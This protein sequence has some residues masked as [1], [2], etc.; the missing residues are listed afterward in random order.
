MT[1][2]QATTGSWHTSEWYASRVRRTTVILT[3]LGITLAFAYAAAIALKRGDPLLLAPLAVALVGLAVLARPTAGVYLLFGIALLFEQTDVPGV[4]PLTDQSH[5]FQRMDMYSSIPIP[6]SVA[7]LLMVLTLASLGVRWIAGRHA[8]LRLGPFGWAVAAYGS[9]FVF[10]ALIGIARGSAWSASAAIV[11]L[12]GPL[13]LCLMYVLATNLIL[14]R[15]QFAILTWVF[16]ILVGLKAI[17]AIWAYQEGLSLPY[18]LDAATGH[19]DVVFFNL[20]LAMLV[21]GVLLGLRTKLTYALLALSPLIVL[22]ELFAQ[23]R[24]AFVAL[25]AVL[26]VIALLALASHPRRAVVAMVLGALAVGAYVPLFWDQ[27]GPLAQPIRALRTAVEPTSVSTRDQYSNRWREVEIRNIEYTVQELP[28]TGVGVGQEMLFREEPG[29]LS[30]A[31]WRYWTHEALLWLWLKAGPLGALAFWFL[32]ARVLLLGSALYARLRE[33]TLRWVAALPVA[34][35]AIQVTYSSIDMGLTHTRPMIVVGTMLGAA[36]F[37][38]TA[39]RLGRSSPPVPV[40][41]K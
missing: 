26:L 17:Q 41:A 15:A 4:A 13:Y 7:D 29:R 30:F 11:E 28:L 19:E 33:P 16:V 40:V 9:V 8:P 35:I 25:G 21:M 39:D 34:L 36:A 6:L 38:F 14:Q 23:R 18:A 32:V 12:R 27:D 2:A 20:A 5:V 37:V 3:G 22:A 10:G 1:A 24:V 31:Y